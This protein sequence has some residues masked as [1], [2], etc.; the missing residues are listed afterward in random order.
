MLRVANFHR[1]KNLILLFV[2]PFFTTIYSFSQTGGIV[3]SPKATDI[4]QYAA[5]ELQRYLY[6]VTGEKLEI[7]TESGKLNSGSFILGQKSTLPL[8]NSLVSETAGHQ[9]YVLKKSG[10]NVIIAGAY[11]GDQAIPVA[12]N[13]TGTG[14]CHTFEPNKSLLLSCF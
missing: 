11:F 8:I 1:M 10:G 13:I 2:L 4:E 5:L 7:L 3:M 9:G 6:Q 14:V 12:Y